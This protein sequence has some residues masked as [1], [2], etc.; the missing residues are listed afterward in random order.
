MQPGIPACKILFP[1]KIFLL[2]A[3]H[4]FG[5]DFPSPGSLLPESPGKHGI[6]QVFPDRGGHGRLR[7]RFREQV[8]L[9]ADTR[10]VM[11]FSAPPKPL[12]IP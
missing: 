1:R 5:S 10:G 4:R 9:R 2:S 7:H 11:L 8:L 3:G 12:Q 6:H